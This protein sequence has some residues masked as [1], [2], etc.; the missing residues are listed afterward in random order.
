MNI[1]RNAQ[2]DPMCEG[3]PEP[4]H[5][6][7]TIPGSWDLSDYFSS[8]D[9]PHAEVNGTAYDKVTGFTHDR[10]LETQNLI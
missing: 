3:H 8:E 6:P 4:F 2:I 1:R 5:M 9:W 10:N 7:R